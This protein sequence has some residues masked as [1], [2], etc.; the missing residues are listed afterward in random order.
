MQPG[1][2]V[3]L[4]PEHTRGLHSPSSP[5]ASTRQEPIE[6]GRSQRSHPPL[7]SALQHTPSTHLPLAHSSPRWQEAP[8]LRRSTHWLP[9]QKWV[10]THTA[11]LEQVVGQLALVPAQRKVPHPGL[12][13]L[14]A[15][16]TAQVP[17]CAAPALMEQASQE[18]AQAALQHTPSAQKPLLHALAPSHG[19]PS[20]RRASQV[21]A[22]QNAPAAQWESLPQVVPQV[23]W[24]PVHRLGKQLG[25]PSL[26][27]GRKV[28]VPGVAVQVSQ[29]PVQL[30]S[31][32]TPAEQTPEAHSAV[33]PQLAPGAFFGRQ[34]L[35]AQ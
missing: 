14:P 23:P 34:V 11:S 24:A 18:P 27:L 2:Q 17:F 25:L 22:L 15:G 9:L 32:H 3:P 5:A 29:L 4:W 13:A 33:L 21:P 6:P 26:V 8:S 31:Q 30:R 1:G 7:H 10:E 16:S 28:Q 12:P 19:W 20:G 35:P